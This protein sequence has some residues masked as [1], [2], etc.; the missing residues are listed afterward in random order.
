MNSLTRIF[1]HLNSIWWLKIKRKPVE[2]SRRIG[3]T[4]G[5]DCQILDN[6]L[7]VF[8]SEPWL[9]TI[10]NQVDI[11]GGVR[12]ICHEG[13]MWCA[14][15][16]KP[17]L[18]DY[19]L[20]RPIRIGNNVMVGTRTVI[21]PG[22]TIGNNVIIAGC[23]VITKDVPDGAVVAGVPAKQISTVDKFVEN[24]K[25]EELFPTKRMTQDQKW[26]YLKKVRPEWFINK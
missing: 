11:T 20:F 16:L 25:M 7:T 1:R 13:G 4:I 23:S 15:R 8:G 6:P 9:I 2:F 5:E 18:M 19:D 3:V 24:I 21:M 10:G 17:E 22:I 26:N 14:R 12:F